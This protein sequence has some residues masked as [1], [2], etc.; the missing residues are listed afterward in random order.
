[1]GRKKKKGQQPLM[2]PSEHPSAEDVPEATEEPLP[3]ELPEEE[4][5]TEAAP[6]SIDESMPQPNVAPV[7]IKAAQ[8]AGELCQHCRRNMGKHTVHEN[9]ICPHCGMLG[10]QVVRKDVEV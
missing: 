1:M 5:K 8:H 3:E 6:T 2:I 10:K 4:E 9:H 7:E